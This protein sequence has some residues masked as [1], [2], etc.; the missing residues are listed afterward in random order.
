MTH[1]HHGESLEQARK[2]LGKKVDLTIDRPIDSLHPQH[3]FIY[4]V[5]YGYVPKTMA[6]DGEEIDAYFL[7][8]SEPCK[9][10]N[11]ICI[12]LVHRF[13]DDDDSLIVVPEGTEINDEEIR[14]VVEFQEKFFD[15]EILRE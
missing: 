6:P 14:R 5:N 1:E 9:T 4:L 10:A 7:G 12:A 2:F 3:G 13:N 8:V 11:G 15:F